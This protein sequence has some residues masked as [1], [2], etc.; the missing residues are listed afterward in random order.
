M[1]ERNICS[2]EFTVSIVLDDFVQRC[3]LFGISR[4]DSEIFFL[5]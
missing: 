1:K 4:L 3:E 5:G 2:D